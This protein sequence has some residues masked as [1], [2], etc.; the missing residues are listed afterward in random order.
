MHATIQVFTYKAGLLARVAH[1]LR[2]SVQRHELSLQAHKLRGFCAAD[3]LKV[4]GVMT[5]HGL[6]ATVLSEKDQRQ[7]LE[8][9]RSEILQSE[10]H[11]RI[12]F[13][14]EVKELSSTSFEARGRLR[15]KSQDRPLVVHL[16]HKG[17]HLQAAFELK[18]S[19]FGI[20][21][22]KALAGAI[23]LEDRV[24]VTIDVALEGKN[25]RELLQSTDTLQL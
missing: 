23:K 11:P 21:P 20:P 24:R 12:E 18:P 13:E 16:E 2:L 3:S 7:I 15:L 25:P 22:Y 8:T 1:D 14:G 10:R 5:A 9:V 6:D 17:D 19:E 4:D